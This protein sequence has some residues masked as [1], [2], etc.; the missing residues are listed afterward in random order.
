MDDLFV[1]AVRGRIPFVICL[2]QAETQVTTMAA[3]PILN[4]S[5]LIVET[6]PTSKAF[7]GHDDIL[8]LECGGHSIQN[9]SINKT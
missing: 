8:V 7:L 4:D 9:N 6:F 3:Q 5:N 1:K 2:V